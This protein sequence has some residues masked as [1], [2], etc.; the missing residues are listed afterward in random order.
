MRTVVILTFF[1]FFGCSQQPVRE[2]VTI[3]DSSGCVEQDRNAVTRV[4]EV[5]DPE[6]KARIAAL[7][8]LAANDPQAAYD[9]G[10]RYFRG[11]EIDRNSYQAIQW[12]RQAA[13]QGDVRAQLA[14][15]RLYM[16][17]YEEM[18]VDLIEADRWLSMA[19][20][21]G[22]S[23]AAALLEE[24]APA[25]EDQRAYDKYRLDWRNRTYRYWY[26][27]PVY[28]YYRWDPTY[29]RYIYP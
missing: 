7:E 17:G 14:L 5:A 13:D 9:L 15:G 24:V 20:A 12:L 22:D 25:L 27:V 2:T 11:D 29:R 18:G 21:Q 16:T 8:E 1:A 23:E 19:A 3:C 28:Y 6:M 26:D 4:D 10:M